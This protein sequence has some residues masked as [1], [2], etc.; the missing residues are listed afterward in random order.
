MRKEIVTAYTKSEDSILLYSVAL[1]S[2]NG[3]L[4]IYSFFHAN[5]RANVLAGTQDMN[6]VLANIKITFR[7]T[8]NSSK[9]KL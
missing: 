1:L 2:D 7:V 5:S 9:T 3:L 8:F 6:I 4:K